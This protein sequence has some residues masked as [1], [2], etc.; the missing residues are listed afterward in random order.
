MAN[1]VE[2]KRDNKSTPSVVSIELI[3]L[4]SA[5]FALGLAIGCFLAP[6]LAETKIM[7]E[8]AEYFRPL[9]ELPPHAFA[10]LIFVNNFLKTLILGLV[11]GVLVAIPPMIFVFLNGLTI[12]LVSSIVAK[13]SGVLFVLLGILPHGTLE[14]PALLISCA[15]GVKVGLTVYNSIKKGGFE[16]GS[17][18]KRC[19]KTYLKVVVP[20]LILAAI[21][22]TYITPLLLHFL[23]Q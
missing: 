20:L 18:F 21:I 5:V 3:M 17:T 12:G 9:I 10:L 13:R 15:L 23:H 7:E 2:A 22:E 6:S 8:L 11:L 14:V 19:I 1:S 4:C 16:V